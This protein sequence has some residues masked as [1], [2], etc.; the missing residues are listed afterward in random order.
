[1]AKQIPFVLGAGARE[2]AAAFYESDSSPTH[3]ISSPLPDLE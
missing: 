1:M 3:V 2:M